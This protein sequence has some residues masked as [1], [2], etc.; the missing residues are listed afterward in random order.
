M[1]NSY[2]VTPSIIPGTL[3]VGGDVDVKGEVRVGPYTPR[4]RIAMVSSNIGGYLYN[5]SANAGSRDD[6]TKPAQGL[7]LGGDT[8]RPSF[9]RVNS[10]GSVQFDAISD[11]M[12][13]DY[14]LHSH[15][16]T[17]T[18]DT[19]WSKTIR[20]NLLGAYSGLRVRLAYSSSV[21]GGAAATVRIKFG[22]TLVVAMSI[23]A[24]GNGFAEI[25][26]GNR[27]VTNAQDIDGVYT[28]PGASTTSVVSSS[29]AVDTTADQA[30]TITVQN[31]TSTDTQAFNDCVMDLINTIQPS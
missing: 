8:Q 16:G 7:Y 23:T 19:I 31:G 22:G 2:T 3:T 28:V 29:M 26:I 11:T 15:T 27:A 4:M 25:V 12:F 21:Q 18:E 24:T 30:I 13:A 1:A 14:T 5:L 20:A 6:P 9:A 10:V 17:T